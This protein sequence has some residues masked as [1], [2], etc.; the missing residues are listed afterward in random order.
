MLAIGYAW[1]SMVVSYKIVDHYFFHDDLTTSKFM[2]IALIINLMIMTVSLIALTIVSCSMK[3]IKLVAWGFFTLELCCIIDVIAIYIIFRS[4]VIEGAYRR[5]VYMSTTNTLFINF[6]N[7]VAFTY[8]YRDT[9]AEGD[10]EITIIRC[11]PLNPANQ[12]TRVEPFDYYK[13]ATC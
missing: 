8:W 4:E 10:E 2:I 11:D 12:E 6:I 7:A 3:S 9:T 1:L 5:N 13:T